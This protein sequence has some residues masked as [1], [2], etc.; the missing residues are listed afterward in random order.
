M[1]EKED[2]L[3][4]ARAKRILSDDRLRQCMAEWEGRGGASSGA[5]I[6]DVAL[7]KQFLSPKAHARVAEHMGFIALRE[8]DKLRGEAAV[9]AGLIK[10]ADLEVGLFL[11][12]KSYKDRREIKR[13]EEYLLGLNALQPDQIPAFREA[14]SAAP[15]PA[16]PEPGAPAPSAE[17]RE[18]VLFDDE[19]TLD[20]PELLQKYLAEEAAEEGSA[21][22][23]PAPGD[24]NLTVLEPISGPEDLPAG[25]ILSEFDDEETFLPPD[26]SGS[27]KKKKKP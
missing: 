21:G 9:R 16:A 22:A 19:L 3:R 6:W 12:R 20:N 25:K 14:A 5:H 7:E 8:E 10:P 17:T 1:D 26:D 2:F 4:L 23:P 24:E 13:I 11:Q 18:A 15:P 27:K